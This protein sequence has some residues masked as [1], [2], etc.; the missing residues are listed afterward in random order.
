MGKA[1]RRLARLGGVAA[2]ALVAGLATSTVAQAAPDNPVRPFIVGGENTTTEENPFVVALLTPQG[3][4]FCGGSL[5]A[6]NKVVTA[7]HC[8]D[9]SKPEDIQVA[10][11]RTKMSSQDGK[12]S[13]VT[14]VWVHPDY[15]DATKGFDVS[16]LTLETELDY[17]PVELAKKDDPGYGE[18][19]NALI[20]GW[21]NTS[22]GGDQS[23]QL[24]KATV[25]VTSDDTCKKAYGEYTPDAMVCAGKPEGGV[26]TCQGDS[27]GP[28]VVDG[29]LIGVT[30][31]G[32]GCARPNKPGVYAR[33]GAYHD[34]LQE[35]IGG[36]GR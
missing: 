21:G 1:S 14:K 24:Q 17:K 10:A 8:T 6:K 23:D 15:T 34:V 19:K 4:Q 28:M 29:K 32:E 26:D 33:V 2:L 20:L 35:Q 36:G 30:S 16:V 31:W 13:K 7:A 12:V 22:E 18:G 11:G 5:V 3:Q 27:G 9:G 25:P